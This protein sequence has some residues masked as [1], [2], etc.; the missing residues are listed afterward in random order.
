M[1]AWSDAEFST[2]TAN[3]SVQAT[4]VRGDGKADVK[5]RLSAACRRLTFAMVDQEIYQKEI[6]GHA[7]W[8]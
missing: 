8:R 2:C 6:K 1:R 7:S 4:F 3:R 5:A